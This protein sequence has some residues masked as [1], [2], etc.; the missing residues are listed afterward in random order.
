M[1][2][3][4]FADCDRGVVGRGMC[5][6]HYLQ[7]WRAGDLDAAP[8]RDRATLICPPSHPHDLD[9]CWAEHRCRCGQCRH[10]RAMDRQRRRNRLIAYGRDHEFRPERVPVGPVREHVAGLMVHAGLERIADAAQVSRSQVL[11][12]YFGPRGADRQ[13]RR[14][15]PQTVRATVAERLSTLRP[16]DI[17]AALVP[18]VGTMRR[19]QGLVSIGYTETE[20]SERLGML[21]TNFNRLI[22]GRRGRVTAATY[23]TTRAVFAE[24]WAHP[25]AGGWADNARAVAKSHRWVGPLAWDDIDDPAELP[26]VRGEAVGGDGLDETAIDLAMH[27]ERVKLTPAERREAVTR[28][29]RERWSDARIGSALGCDDRT[30]LRIRQELG[31]ESFEYGDL[32]KGSVA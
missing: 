26:N 18:A 12:I 17:D 22:L 1:T 13:H 25:K 24:L 28:L 29:H 27:G 32:V 10:L 3:C 6:K 30:V 21:V 5:R 11:D 19:L 2:S 20:L 31:L 9:S 16:D 15:K 14:G 4:S 8:L 7:T 23:Q